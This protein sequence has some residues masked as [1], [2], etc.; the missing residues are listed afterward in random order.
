MLTTTIFAALT[1]LIQVNWR[2]IPQTSV[3][4]AHVTNLLAL[5]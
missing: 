4:V 3:A 2:I 1:V 5:A